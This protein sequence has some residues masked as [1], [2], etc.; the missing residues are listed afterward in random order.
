MKFVVEQEEWQLTSQARTSFNTEPG[1]EVAVKKPK[2]LDSVSLQDATGLSGGVSR[3]LLQ[4]VQVKLLKGD[5]L[6]VQSLKMI[7]LR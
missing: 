7:A 6:L 2:E 1:A 4:R 5:G 3:W